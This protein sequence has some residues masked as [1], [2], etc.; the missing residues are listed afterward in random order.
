ML[1]SNVRP[2][3]THEL[4]ILCGHLDLAFFWICKVT[5]LRVNPLDIVSIRSFISLV[6]NDI[7]VNIGHPKASTGICSDTLTCL[8]E[9]FGT[10][11]APFFFLSELSSVSFVAS[12]TLGYLF[13]FACPTS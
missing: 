9:R 6:L 1:T 7:D 13:F 3:T 12:F 4:I 2:K 8:A 10:Y 11:L 5:Y